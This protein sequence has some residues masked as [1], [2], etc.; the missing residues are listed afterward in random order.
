MAGVKTLLVGL[1]ALCLVNSCFCSGWDSYIDN[2]IAQS[3]DATGVAH[4]DKASIFGLDAS[5]WTSTSGDKMLELSSTEVNTITTVFKSGDFNTFM[6]NGVYVSGVKYQFLRQV[7]GIEVYAKK[8]GNGGIV[9]M[10]S[11]TAVVAAHCPEGKQMGNAAKG[12]TVIAE[13]LDSMNM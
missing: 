4:V 6:S 1:L 13:Y 8:K 3:K 7:D 12:V 2:L 9:M 5:R 10:K 11:K